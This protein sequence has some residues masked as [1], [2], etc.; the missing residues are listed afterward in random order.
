MISIANIRVHD[1]ELLEK[2]L[3]R[4]K[5]FL[6][7]TVFFFAKKYDIIQIMTTVVLNL[8]QKIVSLFSKKEY[9]E[10]G[11][12]DERYTEPLFLEEL[13]DG[14]QIDYC[15]VDSRDVQDFSKSHI[16]TATNVPYYSIEDNLPSENLFTIMI[17]YGYTKRSSIK[18]AEVLKELGYFNVVAFGAYSKWTN[19]VNK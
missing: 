16:D 3:K 10:I 4:F 7:V 12:S 2:A 17:V 18:A 1:D 15:L 8:T 13:I 5:R 19:R 14:Q 6:T 11:F 9:A